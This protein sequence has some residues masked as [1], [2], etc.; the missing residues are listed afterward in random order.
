MVQRIDVHHHVFP[1]EYLAAIDRLGLKEAGGGGVAF[2]DWSPAASIETMDRHGIQTAIV[3]IASPGVYFGDARFARD[4]A[5]R[6]NE[7]SAGLVREH[8]DRFGVF[9]SV[10]L[11]AVDD[12][13][14]EVAYALDTLKCDGLVLMGSVAD[15]FLG[16]PEFEEFVQELDR[17]KTVVFIHPNVHSSSRQLGLKF[18]AALF[19]FLADTTRAVLNLTLSGTLHRY[20]NIRWILS[21]AGGAIPSHA[22]RWALADRSPIVRQNA[23]RGVLT[24][25]RQLYFDTALS[26]SHYAMRP[27]LDLAG[28]KHIVFGSDFPY[29]HA[30]VL[31][32]EIQQ[33]DGLDI[34]DDTTRSMVA[35]QNAFDLFPRLAH[36]TAAAK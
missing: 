4:L 31:D 12:A 27:V 22:W 34:F 35:K 13:I 7:Y 2:P 15:R 33:L 30:E 1:P 26:P 5:R 28:P 36:K 18:P 24:Y 23:S 10:P 8:P 21:H 6:C 16:D 25:I 19:E 20:P 9:A 11:P 14:A 3:S 29:V 32:F 17:R